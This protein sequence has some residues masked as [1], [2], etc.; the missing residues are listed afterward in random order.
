MLIEPSLF[1]LYVM[2]SLLTVVLAQT[3][4]VYNDETP[5]YMMKRDELLFW[6]L[7]PVFNIFIFI[8]SFQ[9]IF[10]ELDAKVQLH[11]QSV[12]NSLNRSMTK[13]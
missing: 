6:S 8:F 5:D 11:V 10:K 4:V 3:A 2:F 12:I 1:S 13:W 9:E 7:F